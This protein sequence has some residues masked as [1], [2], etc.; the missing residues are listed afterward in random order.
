LIAAKDLNE[1]MIVQPFFADIDGK[2][3]ITAVKALLRRKVK[4]IDDQIG[5]CN[6]LAKQTNVLIGLIFNIATLQD[7]IAAVEE[8][9]AANVLAESV[10]RVTV[11]PFVH[12][13][14]TLALVS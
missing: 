2:G 9:C 7:T 10:R 4:I 8:S 12:S 11:L 6:E 3:N 5:R 13:P 14:L 1:Q